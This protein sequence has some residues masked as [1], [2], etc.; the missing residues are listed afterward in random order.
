MP[1]IILPNGEVK[2]FESEK[3]MLETVPPLEDDYGDNE[4]E[5]DA[6]GEEKKDDSKVELDPDVSEGEGEKYVRPAEKY[7]RDRYDVPAWVANT[8]DVLKAI[9]SAIVGAPDSAVGSVQHRAQT[10]RKESGFW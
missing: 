7:K 8:Q 4:Q 3:E 9:P 2:Y 1:R 6:G 5:G 10:T